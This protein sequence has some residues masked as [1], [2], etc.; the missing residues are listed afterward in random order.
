MSPTQAANS[1]SS[2]STCCLR[3]SVS[4][5]TEEGVEGET[6]KEWVSV[7]ES[8]VV[9]RRPCIRHSPPQPFFPFGSLTRNVE[10]WG[11]WI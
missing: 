5:L 1:V 3:S 8:R 6:A 11:R 2:S 7:Y 4:K 9:N 10:M